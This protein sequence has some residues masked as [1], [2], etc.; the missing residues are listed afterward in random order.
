MRTYKTICQYGYSL[1][2]EKPPKIDNTIEYIIIGH[3]IYFPHCVIIKRK[4]SLSFDGVKRWIVPKN[5][6]Y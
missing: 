6:M 2:G 3:S 5:S 1:L 4:D